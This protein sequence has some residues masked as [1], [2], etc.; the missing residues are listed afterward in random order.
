MFLVVSVWIIWLV[1][2]G[3]IKISDESSNAQETKYNILLSGTVICGVIAII[4]SGIGIFIYMLF[5]TGYILS[6]CFK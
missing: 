1:C 5:L 6:K 4:S 3:I 2:L